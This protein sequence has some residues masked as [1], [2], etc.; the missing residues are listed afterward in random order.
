MPCNCDHLEP[1]HREKESKL[2]CELL[3]YVLPLVDLPVPIWVINGVESFYGNTEHLEKA[4]VILCDIC[5]SMSEE[6]ASKVIYYG[7][8]AQARRLA[9]WW[10]AHQAAD[11]E[12]KIREEEAL[13]KAPLS[14]AECYALMDIIRRVD[15]RG[16]LPH[17]P[18]HNW[19]TIVTKLHQQVSDKK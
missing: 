15:K 19:E 3:N 6:K 4:T 8:N 18:R 12:R 17:D 9:D 2:V 14:H 16:E 11:V 7:K 10:E 5:S 1:T 13:T